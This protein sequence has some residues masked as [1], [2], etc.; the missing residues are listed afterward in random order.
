LAYEQF[1]DLRIQRGISARVAGKMGHID[2]S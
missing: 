1:K 2:R